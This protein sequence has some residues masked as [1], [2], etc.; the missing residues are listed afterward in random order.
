MS[1]PAPPSARDATCDRPGGE[2]QPGLSESEVADRRG[3]GLANLADDSTSRSLGTILR[4]NIFT[5]FNGMLAVAW[6]LV[7]ATGRWQ[8]ALFGFAVLINTGIGVVT[9]YRAKL[10]LDNLAILDAPTARVRREGTERDVPVAE[11]VQDDLVLLSTGDQVPVDAEVIT[12]RGLEANE[13]LLTGESRPVR[14]AAGDEVLSGSSIVAG[15]ALVRATH[16]GADA[17]A[18]RITAAARR[19]SLA[20]SEL[21]QAIRSILRVVSWIIVPMALLLAASQVKALGGWD[22]MVSSGTWRDAVVQAVAGVIGMIP[23]GLVLL[24]SL[25]FAMAA[26]LLA[27]QKVLVQELPAVEILARVDVLCLDKTGTI[28]DGS[29]ACR[30]LVW[31]SATGLPGHDPDPAALAAL[32]AIGTDPEGNVTARAIGEATEGVTAARV[33]RTVPFSSARKWSAL[34]DGEAAWVLGAPEIV[35]AE[36]RDS[37]SQAALSAARDLAADG[38]RVVLLARA[39]AFPDPDAGLG[40][41]TPTV[42]VV[43]GERV[44]ED[45]QRTLAFFRE[46][47][48][49]LHVISGDNPTTVA[50]IASSVELAGPGATVEGAD[51]RE[52]STDLGALGA[53]LATRPVLGRV[54]PDQKVAIVEA[55]QAR[56]RTVAMTG[57]GV[58]DALAIKTADLGIAMGNG[59]RATKAVS[60]LVLMDG[61]FATLPGVVA[62]GRRVIANMDRV[63]NLFLVKTSYSAVLALVTVLVSFAVP[64]SY[65]FL[66]RQITLISVLTIGLPGFLLSLPPSAQRYRPGFLRRVLAFA[67]PAGLVVAV[68]ALAMVR[69]ASKL[70]ESEEM[71]RT[72]ATMSTLGLGMI[73]VVLFCGAFAWW[74]V[75]MVAV[76]AAAGFAAPYLPL[77]AEFFLLQRPD[78][79]NWGVVAIVIVIGGALLVG[80][81]ILARHVTGGRMPSQ[82]SSGAV[83]DAAVEDVRQA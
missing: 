19:Y 49:D 23:E 34:D 56:G 75:A 29:V 74:K 55:L 27:T 6:V 43:L 60:R 14:K 64:L 5:L 61:R 71:A 1:T 44:R 38:S 80:L 65:P 3:R 24:V 39:G 59:A 35:L 52:L 46:Q 45:A 78:A 17:Y 69:V 58:N 31:L 10:T 53:E 48:V 76:F 36:R 26:A 32:A 2:D 15:S 42:L 37:A 83:A 25:N 22:V 54:T 13:S 11:L 81:R 47:G 9:E 72:L 28:T 62:Q 12:S 68:M 63:A 66:P 79:E 57:D 73:V 21:Q 40:E 18:Q 70:G 16:V 30:E 51:A 41:C 50:A 8:D 33:A 20:T 7:M 4:A 77:A 82:A 67:L